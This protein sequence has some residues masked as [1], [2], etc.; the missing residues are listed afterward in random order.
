MQQQTK[1]T[2]RPD[3]DYL[4]ARG[5]HGLK[6]GSIRNGQEDPTVRASEMGLENGWFSFDDLRMLFHGTNL[7]NFQDGP[8]HGFTGWDT[9]KPRSGQWSLN[10]MLR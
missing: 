1:C 8:H 7:T 4:L 10:Q 5:E 9:R 3:V 6:H 2:C